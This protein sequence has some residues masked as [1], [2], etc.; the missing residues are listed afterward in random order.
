MLFFL[1]LAEVYGEQYYIFRGNKWDWFGFVTSS[2]YLANLSDNDYFLLKNNFSLGTI[3]LIASEKEKLSAYHNTILTWIDKIPTLSLIGAIFLKINLKN[4]FYMTHLYKIF[5]LMLISISFY[6]FLKKYSKNNFYLNIFNTIVVMLSFWIIYIVEADYFRMLAGFSIYIYL[7]LNIEDLFDDFNKN[8]FQRLFFIM[9]SISALILIYP[10]ILII[11]FFIFIVY[12]ILLRKLDFTFIK[13]NFHKFVIFLFLIFVCIFPNIEITINFLISQIQSTQYENRWWTYFGA[14]ILGR[15]NPAI[16]PAFS[17]YVKQLIYNSPNIVSYHDNLKFT[18][19]FNIINHSIIKF[20]FTHVYLNIIPSIFGYY[21]FT[22]WATN[23][24]IK[25][26]SYIFLIFFSFYLIFRSVK[27]LFYIFYSKKNKFIL[28]KSSVIVFIIFSLVFLIKG[29]IWTQLKLYFYFTPIIIILVLFKSNNKKSTFVHA[30][31]FL[32]IL[33]LLFP[34]YKFNNFNYGINT[35]DTF[36]SIQNIKSKKDI[37]WKFNIE[38]FNNCS[39]VNLD[40][41]KWDYFNPNTIL[42]HFKEIY[43]TINLINLGYNF[44]QENNNLL[45]NKN[46]LTKKNCVV[47]NL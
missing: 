11:I 31:Y 6:D 19:I 3:K 46:I 21:F 22:D 10:E 40:F 26:L 43:I 45:I 36:P 33:M 37:I 42:D 7:L 18:E 20:N 28:I 5:S 16:D 17:E 25:Y 41:K 34:I 4:I 32:M 1:T 12:G 30:D 29:K 39:N 8:N 23:N 14:F 9:L 13:K 44:Q 35:Y 15:D 27:N 2:H 47:N 38:D 24:I